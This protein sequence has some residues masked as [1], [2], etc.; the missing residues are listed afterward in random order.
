[1]QHP[2]LERHGVSIGVGDRSRRVLGLPREG[3]NELGG[4]D[5]DE[6]SC[7]TKKRKEKNAENVWS[8]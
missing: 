3:R 8:A 2:S 4:I 5:G 6:T 1:M 7:M